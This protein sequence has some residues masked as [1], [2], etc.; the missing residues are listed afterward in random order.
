[1]ACCKNNDAVISGLMNTKQTVPEPEPRKRH[2]R[3][4][5]TVDLSKRIG[6]VVTITKTSKSTAAPEQ[7][8]I[9]N[10]NFAQQILGDKQ[11]SPVNEYNRD[12]FDDDMSEITFGTKKESE[13]YDLGSAKIKY[14]QRGFIL[15]ALN[16]DEFSA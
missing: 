3:S 10:S 4:R 8:V 11:S 5:R 16:E 6:E 15:P 12:P 9:L 1:M 2:S 13:R 7:N 14:M